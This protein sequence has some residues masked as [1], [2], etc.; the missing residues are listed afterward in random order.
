MSKLSKLES[1]VKTLFFSSAAIWLL[2]FFY[3]DRLPEP[4]FYNPAFLKAPIQDKTYREPFEIESNGNRYRITP[5]YN[6]HLNGVVVT[7]SDADGFLNIWHHRRWKDFVNLKDLCVIWGENVSSGVYR[8]MQFSSDSWTCWAQWGPE[9]APYFKENQLSNNH[10][11]SNELWIKRK[12]METEPGDQIQF[13]GML[14]RYENLDNNFSRGSSTSRDDR[15]NGA[16]E[17]VFLNEFR[18]I[19]KANPGWRFLYSSSKIMTIISFISLL[20]LMFTAPITN[21]RH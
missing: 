11:L 16:C 5:L 13:S 2:A 7:Y 18:I 4:S 20:I 3:K 10:L 1:F 6:Y 19:K 9:A 15:G 8:K 17:T 14:V 21:K 12:L